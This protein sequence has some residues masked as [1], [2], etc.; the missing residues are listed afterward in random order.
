MNNAV[1]TTS[2]WQPA[3]T[4]ENSQSL[5]EATTAGNEEAVARAI[6][7]AH[8]ENTSILSYNDENSLACVLTIAY[9]WAR[10]EYI[11]H[12]EYATGKGY[13]DLV[14]IPRR[15]VAKP[16]LIIELKC[17][18]SADT[19]IDQIK[20]KNYPA[21]IAE[22]AGDML[23]VGINYDKATKQHTCKIERLEKN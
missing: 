22:Y 21:K 19:A 16:A 1:T 15:H 18:H 7:R 8:D 9:I 6:D 2:W 4:L 17:S 10:N 13:A 5:L 3:K 11:V 23:L 20:R 12:R 14:M